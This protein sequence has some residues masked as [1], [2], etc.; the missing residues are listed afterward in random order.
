MRKN[1]PHNQN[2]IKPKAT[3]VISNDVDTNSDEYTKFLM[4]IDKIRV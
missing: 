4:S 3:Q 2:E 1:R